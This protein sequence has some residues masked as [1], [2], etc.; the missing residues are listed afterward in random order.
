MA[1]RRG[2]N[3]TQPSKRR[4][5]SSCHQG[6][7]WSIKHWD[8]SITGWFL[9]QGNSGCWEIVTVHELGIPVFNQPSSSNN[10]FIRIVLNT[11]QVEMM[12]ESTEGGFDE[13]GPFDATWNHADFLVMNHTDKPDIKG[14][15]IGFGWCFFV[16]LWSPMVLNN[17]ATQP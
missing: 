12:W 11:A 9:H 13:D 16:V 4:R 15:K 10:R 6:W 1:T 2:S 3:V 14:C 5:L 8:L 7:E 17:A